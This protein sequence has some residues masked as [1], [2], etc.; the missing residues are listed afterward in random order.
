MDALEQAWRAWAELGERLRQS[1]WDSP[2]RLEGWTVKDVFAHHSG[3]PAGIRSGV[4]APEV[5]A[6]TT[7][8]DA[9]ALLAYMQQPGGIADATASGLQQEAVALARKRSTAELVAQFREVAPDVLADLRGRDL[10]RRVD[11]G[12][13]AV[14]TASEALRIFLLEAV[15]HYFDMAV[16]LDLPVP[17]PMAGEPLHATARL[18]AEVADP[19]ALIDAATG[20]GQPWV[21]PVLR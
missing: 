2:T 16:A 11:Y 13:L 1:E 3:F 4:Q 21:F 5:T 12:G 19:V 7:H 20:R 6:P 9:A 14:I 18:L 15:V 8:A 10:E 17:G